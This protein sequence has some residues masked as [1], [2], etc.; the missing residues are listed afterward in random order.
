MGSLMSKRHV[1]PLPEKAQSNAS[2]NSKERFS[3]FALDLW[4]SVSFL[5]LTKN[6]TIES[7]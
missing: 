1:R 7:R 2:G 5:C 4:F 6:L 3:E